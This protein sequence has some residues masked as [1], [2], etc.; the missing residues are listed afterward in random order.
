MKFLIEIAGG[1]ATALIRSLDHARQHLLSGGCYLNVG[2]SVDVKMR[3]ENE[4]TE[5]EFRRQYAEAHPKPARSW[6]S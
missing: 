2:G 3:P 1:D 6:P 4:D 5:E